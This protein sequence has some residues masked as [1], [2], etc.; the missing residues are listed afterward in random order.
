MLAKYIRSKKDNKER[1]INQMI[2]FVHNITNGQQDGT[3]IEYK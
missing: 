3:T 2:E 1:L